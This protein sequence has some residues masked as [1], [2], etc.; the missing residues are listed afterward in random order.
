MKKSSLYLYTLIVLVILLI[1]TAFLTLKPEP[2][3]TYTTAHPF[4]GSVTQSISASGT[5]SATN[6]FDVGTQVSGTIYK[7]YVDVND[8][9]KKDQIL[10][11]INPNKLNQTLEGYEAQKLIAEANL[12]SSQVTYE[13]KKWTYERQ[14]KLFE[15]TNGASPSQLDLE[16]A[17]LAYL[18]AEAD[19]EVKKSTLNQ[20]QTDIN[21]AKI[22]LQNAIIRSPIDGIVLTRDVSLGQTV[23]ASFSTPTLFTLAEN[24]KDM[25]LVVNI[26]ESDIGK[27]K[28]DQKVTFSVD[29]YPNQVFEAKVNR[30]NFA[31]TTTDN[32]TSYETSIYVNN[33]ALLLRPGMSATANIQINEAKNALLV[34]VAAIFYQPKASP[35][36]QKRGLFFAPRPPQRPKQNTQQKQTQDSATI[37]ILKDNEVVRVPVKI[38]VQ[39]SKYVQIISPELDLNTLVITD[40]K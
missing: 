6:D 2:T 28:L 12:K 19:V 14:K 9:V 34:P 22:D 16:T 30:V 35:K 11:E 8:V 37:Y 33:D 1:I 7:I 13:Q 24:L 18:Q 31:S 38:G 36:E 39:S 40:S 4:I 5:L 10:A 29:A 17:R 20:I 21:T 23:A 25:K 3:I 26:S 15:K 27:V 32:I